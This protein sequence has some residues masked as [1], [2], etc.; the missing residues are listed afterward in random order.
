[1]DHATTPATTVTK[2]VT[3]RGETLDTVAG[4]Q[5]T[6]V[7]D[8]DLTDPN[9]RLG[10]VEAGE[11]ADRSGRRDRRS[12]AARTHAVAGINGDYSR[13]TPAAARSGRESPTA[14]C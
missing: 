9:V 4:R 11:H 12:M 5:H 13:S 8:V 10:V 1:V 14:N 6:Q 2:G 7:L 3:E